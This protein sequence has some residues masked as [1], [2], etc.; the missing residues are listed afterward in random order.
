M[1]LL[2]NTFPVET[3][4]YRVS[5]QLS[6]GGDLQKVQFKRYGISIREKFIYT[7]AL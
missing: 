2:T 5:P 7:T 4:I 3:A 1:L 6:V